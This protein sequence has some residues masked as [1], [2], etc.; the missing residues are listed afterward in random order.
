MTDLLTPGALNALCAWWLLVV[1]WLVIRGLLRRSESRPTSPPVS[2][3]P[4]SP[5][6]VRPQPSSSQLASI[7]PR[8]DGAPHRQA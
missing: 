4:V 7:V 8:H 2:P 6:T 5:R 3:R 1:G